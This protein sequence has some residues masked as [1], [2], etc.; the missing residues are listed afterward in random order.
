MSH[1]PLARMTFPAST[2]PHM[3]PACSTRHSSSA[4]ACRSHPLHA[5]AM[6]ERTIAIAHV[7]GRRH[8]GS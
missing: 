7:Q 6:L 5:P 4:A 2:L 3:H 8:L 1:W